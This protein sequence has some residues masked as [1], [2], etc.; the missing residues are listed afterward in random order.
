MKAFNK[1]EVDNSG[2]ERANAAIA[3]AQEAANSLE[4]NFKADLSTDNVATV[5][6]GGTAQAV[7]ASSSVAK[8]RRT[9]GGLASQLGIKL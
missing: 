8:R 5:T 9:P 2:V 3:K 7:E 4:K 1:P 6:P